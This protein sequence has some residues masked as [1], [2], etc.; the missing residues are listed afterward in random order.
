MPIDDVLE[1]NYGG[2]DDAMALNYSTDMFSVPN[3]PTKQSHPPPD[4]SLMRSA[5]LPDAPIV[6]MYERLNM[7][8][9]VEACHPDTAMYM[10]GGDKDPSK[11]RTASPKPDSLPSNTHRLQQQYDKLEQHMH[12]DVAHLQK[13][14]ALAAD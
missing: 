13:Q 5:N 14:L 8:F 11:G 10:N 2:K 4:T 6:Q 7:P 12:R 3:T 1:G 9:P